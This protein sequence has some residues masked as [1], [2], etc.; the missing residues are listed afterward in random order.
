[1]PR[2]Q[3]LSSVAQSISRAG[4]TTP[5][6]ASAHRP[7]SALAEALLWLLRWATLIQAAACFSSAKLLLPPL[8][9]R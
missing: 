7:T 3:T 6:M 8:M 2:G 9:Q 1:M 5:T 4:L